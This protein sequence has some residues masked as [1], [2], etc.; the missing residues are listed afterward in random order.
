MMGKAVTILVVDDDKV[1][2]MALRRCFRDL[3][4]E[5]PVV[6]TRS[7]LEALAR[8]RGTDGRP[9]LAQPCLVVLDLN[10]P[11]MSGLEFIDELRRDP[12]LRRTLIFV[13]TTSAAPEDVNRCYE[14]NVAGY[15]LKHRSDQ[16]FRQTVSMLQQYW[17]IVAFPN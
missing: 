2:T 9:A 10:M 5:N 11:R 8:L 1:D 13:M 3:C 14:K 6:E 17:N 12:V 4:I 16:P 15:T 7:G